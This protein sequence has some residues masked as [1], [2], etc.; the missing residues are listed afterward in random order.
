MYILYKQRGRREGLKESR[1]AF[2]PYMRLS[3]VHASQCKER[4]TKRTRHYHKRGDYYTA[5]FSYDPP[6][7][8][9]STGLENGIL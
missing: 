3:Q 5:Y 7:T 6:V 4:E 2:G 1:R 9:Y 8:M